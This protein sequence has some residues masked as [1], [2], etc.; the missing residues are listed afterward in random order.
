MVY[1]CLDFLA[2][3]KFKCLIYSSMYMLRINSL[4]KHHIVKVSRSNKN[5]SFVNSPNIAAMCAPY[6]ITTL[7]SGFMVINTGSI[8]PDLYLCFIIAYTPQ[9]SSSLLWRNASS[10]VEQDLTGSS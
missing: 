8:Y 6:I 9:D 4:A 2:L 7:S 5:V 3:L 1:F 10:A